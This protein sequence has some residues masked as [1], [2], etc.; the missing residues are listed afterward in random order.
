MA[1]LYTRASD[2]HSRRG[3]LAIVAEHA[4][5]AHTR[6]CVRTRVRHCRRC[7]CRSPII[8]TFVATRILH[9]ILVESFLRAPIVFKDGW[10]QLWR[11]GTEPNAASPPSIFC[12]AAWPEPQLDRSGVVR[13][14]AGEA[15]GG[16]RRKREKD[17]FFLARLNEPSAAPPP[18]IFCTATWLESQLVRS[19]VLGLHARWCIRTFGWLAWRPWRQAR[20]CHVG[21]WRG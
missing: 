8:F 16:G 5:A 17:F 7:H 20:G 13:F 19:G 10:A 1:Q 15:G 2:A 9:T 12:A 4:I 6:A 18:S 21:E 14:H 11:C 3:K